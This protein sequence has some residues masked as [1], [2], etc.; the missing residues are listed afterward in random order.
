[1]HAQ[2]PL[3]PVRSNKTR[4]YHR[5]LDGRKRE[6]KEGRKKMKRRTREKGGEKEKV[7]NKKKTVPDLM[8]REK[9]ERG[10]RK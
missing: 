1:M 6:S 2:I 9:R 8:T 5:K 10:E 7:R 3:S 4:G